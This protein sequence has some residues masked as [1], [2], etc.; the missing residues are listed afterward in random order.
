MSWRHGQPVLNVCS[1][2]TPNSRS[3]TSQLSWQEPSVHLHTLI[4]SLQLDSGKRPAQSNGLPSE[5]KLDHLFNINFTGSNVYM[6]GQLCLLTAL[7]VKGTNLRRLHLGVRGWTFPRW[8]ETSYAKDNLPR[9]YLAKSLILKVT[10]VIKTLRM[11]RK[12]KAAPTVWWLANAH[13]NM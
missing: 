13:M 6:R 9:I 4:I 1:N 2:P 7:V 5:G 12:A 10:N 8:R 3:L 11:K